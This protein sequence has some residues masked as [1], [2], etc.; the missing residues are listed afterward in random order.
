MTDVEEQVAGLYAEQLYLKK[1][2][3]SFY[4]HM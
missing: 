3:I 2:Q 4:Y 1:E